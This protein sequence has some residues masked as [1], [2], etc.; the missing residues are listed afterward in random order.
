MLPYLQAAA[1]LL[2]TLTPLTATGAQALAVLL[3]GP[4]TP[5]ASA[6]ASTPS[7]A[8]A[9]TP[10]GWSLPLNPIL[11]VVVLHITVLSIFSDQ[12]LAACQV[13]PIE[14]LY[15]F[16]RLQVTKKQLCDGIV[17]YL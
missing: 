9:P 2:T 4:W 8:H 6:P 1:F 11:S 14:G 13:C 16:H 7:A 12:N 10:P 3:A 15:C 5:V 17:E